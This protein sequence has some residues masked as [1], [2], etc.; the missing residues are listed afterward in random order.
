MDESQ[1]RR[2]ERGQSNPIAV[3][4]VFALVIASTTVIVVFGATAIQ[5]SQNQL[6][7]QTAENAMTQL[8][9]QAS[10]VA[11]GSSETQTVALGGTDSSNYRVAEGGTM[12]VTVQGRADPILEEE[13][14]SVVYEDD[15][16]TTIAYQG[17]GVWRTD[18]NGDAVMV[19]PPEL[20][21]RNETLT[22]PLVTVDGDEDGSLSDSIRI[23]Q[24]S[25]Y[26]AYPNAS[27][28]LANPVE[29]GLIQVTVQ[30]EYYRA[31]A[32]YFRTRTSGGVTV[33]DSNNEVTLSLLQ[34]EERT[35]REPLTVFGGGSGT[36]EIQSGN[37]IVIDNY[38]SSNTPDD[39]DATNPPTST[40][41]AG[42]RTT[43]N[44]N[45]NG[46]AEINGNLTTAGSV[47]FSGS[48][49]P[50]SG[51]SENLRYGDGSV[52]TRDCDRYVGGWCNDNASIE[53]SGSLDNE[54]DNTI[55][56]YQG[57]NDNSETD[58][59]DRSTGLR[60]ADTSCTTTDTV[61]LESGNYY[62]ENEN[63]VVE[64]GETL[65]LDTTDGNVN[66]GVD[67]GNEVQIYGNV[68]VVGDGRVSVYATDR[69]DISD[70]DSL[71]WNR[72]WDANQFWLYCDAGCEIDVRRGTYNGVIYAP[73]EAGGSSGDIEIRNQ[74]QVYGAIIAG[75]E[76]TAELGQQSEIYFDES[77]ESSTVFERATV[78]SI[79]YLHVS[80]NRVNVTSG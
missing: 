13:L 1:R 22:L 41:D 31:W 55:S 75:G 4:L 67:D 59:V 49:Q 10:L 46:N 45:F 79:S 39:L 61:T 14:G 20:H 68:T 74:A 65:V 42:V 21:Y 30:S 35:I 25:T 60:Y 53:Q 66:I 40:G 80:V 43:L 71:V 54:I 17:G 6:G 73:P 32:D 9:S 64:N 27:E 76:S 8:D 15:S 57:E 38:N 28:S 63:L 5:D 52:S 72:G 33:D 29:D 56:Q 11:L 19:S 70:R 62:L 24:N 51:V 36:L 37:T 58:C 50:R 48:G 26:Q 77:L 34:E 69:I 3:V 2:S 44:V 7:A 47:A 18:G 16:G 23:N 12:T 78:P